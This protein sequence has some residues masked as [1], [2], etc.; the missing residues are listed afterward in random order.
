MN[1]GL[2]VTQTAALKIHFGRTKLA[3]ATVFFLSRL[4]GQD[5]FLAYS[6]LVLF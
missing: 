1:G 3:P 6:V 4:A 2:D 5:Q